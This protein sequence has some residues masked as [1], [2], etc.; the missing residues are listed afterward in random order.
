VVVV[1]KHPAEAISAVDATSCSPNAIVR[2]DEVVS[3]TL[4]IPL[5]VIVGELLKGRL[6]QRRLAGEDHAVQRL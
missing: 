1:A 6:S 3:E 2:L 4:V 5:S